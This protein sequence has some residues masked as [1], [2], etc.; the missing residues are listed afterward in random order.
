MTRALAT[1]LLLTLTLVGCGSSDSEKKTGKDKDGFSQAADTSTCTADA[2]AFTG[3]VP[4]NY[5]KDFPLPSG[6]VLYNVEDRGNDGA[7]G[8]AVVKASLKDVLGVMNGTA[9]DAGFKVTGGETE[10]HDAEANW[11]GNGFRGRWAIRES[12]KCDGE[13]VIQVLAKRQ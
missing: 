9:Q 12:A 2:Q 5:P 4:A 6:A 1:L 8:T 10:E 3:T 7:I 11:T 13:I